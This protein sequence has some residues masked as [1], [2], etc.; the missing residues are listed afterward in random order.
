MVR[1][2]D[3]ELQFA[4]LVV[5]VMRSEH[6]GERIGSEEKIMAA[7]R[8]LQLER[9]VQE[10]PLPEP[11]DVIRSYLW[12][13]LA[14]AYLHRHVGEHAHNLEEALAA[15]K[16]AL[17]DIAPDAF[18]RQWAAA[19][20]G[21]GIVYEKRI[22][23]DPAQNIEESI[24]AYDRA[25]TVFR[26]DT[27]PQEWAQTQNLLGNAYDARIRG[28]RADNVEKAIEAYEAALTIQ[29]RETSAIH[30]ADTQHNLGLAYHDRIR[31][32]RVENTQRSLAAYEAALTVRTKTAM[33]YEW[34]MTMSNLGSTLRDATTER[35]DTLEKAIAAHQAAFEIMKRLAAPHDWSVVLNQLGLDYL[36]R[37]QGET[38]GNLQ[39]AIE[40]FECVLTVIPRNTSQW[41]WAQVHNNLGIAHQGLGTIRGAESDKDA[42]LS[43]AIQAY[44]AALE[45]ITPVNS[46]STWAEINHNLG[47]VYWLR[48]EGIRE[49]NLKQSIAAYQAALTIYTREGLPRDHL[50]TA[51]SL[52]RAYLELRNWPLASAAYAS[53]RDA[54]SFLLGQGLDEA[55]VLNIIAEAGALFSESAFVAAENGEPEVGLAVLLEGKAR[56]LGVAIK[57]QTLTLSID[58]HRRLDVLRGQIQAET[59]IMIEAMGHD[60]N[61]AVDRLTA[62][63][64]EVEALIKLGEPSPRSYIETLT[65][66]GKMVSPSGVLVAPVTTKCGGKIFLL[67]AHTN[68][69]RVTVIQLPELTSQRVETIILGNPRNNPRAW[70]PAYFTNHLPSDQR[71]IHIGNWLTAIKAIGVDIWQLFAG[72]LD[73]I[74][75]KLGLSDG[76]RLIWIPTGMLGLLPLCLAED[77][78][79]G[80]LL[81]DGYEIS[82]APS[83]EAI[84]NANTRIP[85]T[86]VTS[87]AAIIN[88]TG[89]LPFAEVEG[90]LVASHFTEKQR[91]LLDKSNA[92]PERVLASLKGRT[93][94]HFS[95]HGSFNWSNPRKSGLFMKDAIPITLGKLL[96][97]LDVSHPRLVVLSACETGLYDTARTPDEFIGLPSAFMMLGARGV[98]GTLW[99]VD[100]RATALLI[101]KFYDLHLGE[102]FAPP[103]ALKR[104]QTWLRAASTV[105]LISYIQEAVKTGR[106]EGN[107]FVDLENSL[108]QGIHA[109][110]RFRFE[111]IWLQDPS[112]EGEPHTQADLD[113]RLFAHPYYWGAFT[114]T[115]L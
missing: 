48:V 73:T 54:F 86:S 43:R 42:N 57:L 18:P 41:M 8:A 58:D 67:T 29:T 62:L 110:E 66:A 32:T 10:W 34:A 26:R 44:E 38:E 7:Q 103:A 35:R 40:A 84:M 14:T 2:S 30:W 51:R 11:Q 100:D 94:W 76:A 97:S 52:G 16:E 17:R 31:G 111:R 6:S 104:A 61:A 1:Y 59:R 4:Q 9:L 77:P 28:T 69:S 72:E 70:L 98:V 78:T 45:V 65:A 95:A 92:E 109:D 80:R 75:K 68:G 23:G 107:K 24:A 63:R 13:A 27:F 99:P 88:P 101:A 36:Y 113:A 64:Q 33:P 22:L 108:R 15:H 50:H 112:G 87:L 83:L 82:Y 3:L 115:G 74:L 71:H 85:E 105:D 81:I 46:P 55:E 25:L 102:G 114:Y 49:D 89:D 91:S 20:T 106:L 90:S 79:S 19:Q 47:N 56:L 21:L 39:Q 93:Y 12:S 5:Q 37:V 60:R 96:E 53:A